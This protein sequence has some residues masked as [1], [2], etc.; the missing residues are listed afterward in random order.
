MGIQRQSILDYLPIVQID[1]EEPGKN[2]G[3]E[4]ITVDPKFKSLIPPL[5]QDEYNGLEE[6][7]LSEVAAERY[8]EYVLLPGEEGGMSNENI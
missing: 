1:N 8:C 3:E 2:V 5:S 6:R 4:V 7:E